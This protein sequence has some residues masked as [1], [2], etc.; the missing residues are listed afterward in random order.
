[1]SIAPILLVLLIIIIR[2]NVRKKNNEGSYIRYDLTDKKI[3]TILTGICFLMGIVPAVIVYP[4]DNKLTGK[5]VGT[6]YMLFVM[7][8]YIICP[9]LMFLFVI[10]AIRLM[11]C[12]LY[13]NR[14]EK[15][16]Y[17]VPVRAKEYEYNFRRLQRDES[18]EVTEYPGD[19]RVAAIISAVATTGF[20]IETVIYAIKWMPLSPQIATMFLVCALIMDGLWLLATYQ[21]IKRTNALHFRDVTSPA[22]CRKVRKDVVGAVVGLCCAILVSVFCVLLATSV[23]DT[24]YRISLR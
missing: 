23:T 20:L 10:F 16:G 18:V 14:L 22:D 21:N 2:Q 17:T 3:Y 12:N 13:L 9:C 11:Q 8:M 5:L 1:M 6:E 4:M 19:S 15:N 7:V 24:F